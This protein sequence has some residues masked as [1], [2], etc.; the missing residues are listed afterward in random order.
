MHN[1][2]SNFISTIQNLQL[3]DLGSDSVGMLPHTII[4]G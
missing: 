1:K 2:I 4:S 3:F